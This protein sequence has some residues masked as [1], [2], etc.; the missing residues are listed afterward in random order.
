[1]LTSLVEEIPIPSRES[2][3][4]L[5]RSHPVDWEA[6]AARL[7][8]LPQ[9]Y[10]FALVIAG[11]ALLVAGYKIY[12][13]ALVLS[14]I[15]AG[16]IIGVTLGRAFNINPVVVGIICAVVMGILALP[17][18]KVLFFIAGGA[19]GVIFVA[20]TLAVIFKSLDERFWPLWLFL[21]FVMLGV[22]MVLF[23]KQIVI[24][25]TAI[26]GAVLVSFGCVMLI[27]R[28]PS[29]SAHSII[30]HP[31]LVILILILLLAMFGVVTQTALEQ[32][33]KAPAKDTSQG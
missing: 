7:S 2:L 23:F 15:V 12:R 30:L 4:E 19:I 24:I 11:L 9:V 1:M 27:Q 20:P 10:I 21:G 17:L 14:G 16:A 32:K 29:R 18:Q 26:E 33:K 3:E 22:L 6:L 25:A 13:V 31:P 5:L 8:A 28:A